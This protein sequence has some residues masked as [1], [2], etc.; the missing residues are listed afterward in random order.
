[1]T[2]TIEQYAD[3]K[4]YIIDDLGFLDVGVA[5]AEFMEAEAQRLEAW[6]EKGL[7]AK[8]DYMGNHFDLRTDPTKLVP[9]AKTVIS[10]LYNYYTPTK[11]VDETAPKLS[12]Y[13]FGRDYHKVIKKKLKRIL[14]WMNEHIGD[15][16]GR[17]F[18]DS[19]PVLERD[20]ARRAGLGWIGK[21]TLLINQNV[22][23]YFFLAELIVDLEID[24]IKEPVA[25]HCGTCTRCIDSCPTLAISDKG[26]ELD[27]S[28][29]ISY[30]TIELKEDIPSEFQN[31]LEQWMF[32]CDICQTVCPWNRFSTPHKEVAFEPSRELVT[33]NKESWQ[34]ISEE[35]FDHLFAESAVKRAGF[36]KLKQNI[37]AA[38]NR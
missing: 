24:T 18:V 22:G 9:G 28:K 12:M 1:M 23:S 11:Q 17:A 25:D 26:Y 2:L 4:S 14:S 32:G 15:V 29:C 38:L 7:H 37:K 34:A 36:N 8:M 31:S 16:Q 13:A 10:L 35:E 27:A 33:K 19:A 20:W 6:L 3:L 5:K 21:H 30:L